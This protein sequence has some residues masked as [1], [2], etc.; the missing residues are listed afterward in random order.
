MIF[1]IRSLAFHS[2]LIYLFFNDIHYYS[3]PNHLS[4]NT[5]K[6]SF[7]K[8][9]LLY[10]ESNQTLKSICIFRYFITNY[11]QMKA[12]NISHTEKIPLLWHFSDLKVD[13]HA[14]FGDSGCLWRGHRKYFQSSHKEEIQLILNIFL[15]P[16]ITLEIL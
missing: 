13:K 4:N 1:L 14:L 5:K 6:D 9:N 16:G 12:I 15:V 11:L 2:S 8:F 3:V 10:F 7:E